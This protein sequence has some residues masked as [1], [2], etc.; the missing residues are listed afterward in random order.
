MLFEYV[1]VYKL[2]VQ[3]DVELCGHMGGELMEVSQRLLQLL[4]L[5]LAPVFDI[6]YLQ[7]AHLLNDTLNEPYVC[8]NHIQIQPAQTGVEIRVTQLIGGV[9]DKESILVHDPHV[10]VADVDR[11]LID[12]VSEYQ[13]EYGNQLSILCKYLWLSLVSLACQLVNGYLY[14]ICYKISIF[15]Q[16]PIEH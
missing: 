6:D 15:A 7:I 2:L 8:L 11:N 10:I 9:L 14:G 3:L 16:T 5:V 13:H 12:I 1:V 4:E